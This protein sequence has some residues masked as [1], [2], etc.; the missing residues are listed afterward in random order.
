MWEEDMVIPHGGL[1]MDGCG[2]RR[3]SPTRNN[4]FYLI[5]LQG[6]A[7]FMPDI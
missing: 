7:A 4:A 2:R 1:W 3:T 6:K 5:R